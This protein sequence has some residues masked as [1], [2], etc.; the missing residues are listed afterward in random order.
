MHA[1]VCVYKYFLSPQK[2]FT[3]RAYRQLDE[4]ERVFGVVVSPNA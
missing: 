3:H 2:Y 1:W 4:R